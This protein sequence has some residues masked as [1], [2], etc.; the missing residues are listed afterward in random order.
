M[1]RIVVSLGEFQGQSY[2]SGIEG[3]QGRLSRP[4]VMVLG[5]GD[6]AASNALEGVREAKPLRRLSVPNGL[7]R[8]AAG[9]IG[10]G[11]AWGD[12]GLRGDLAALSAPAAHG[13][14]ARRSVSKGDRG[15]IVP[16]NSEWRLGPVCI[17][18]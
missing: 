14:R 1:T 17:G 7:A 18:T 3:Q 9:A 5:K 6:L 11:Q 15:L 13:K 2:R 10:G 4:P 12:V 8:A 16:A